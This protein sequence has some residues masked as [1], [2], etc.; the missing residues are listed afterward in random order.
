MKGFSLALTFLAAAVVSACTV[1]QTEAPPLTGPSELALSIS[2]SAS[3]DTLISGGLQQSSV[4]LQARDASGA[5]KANQSFLL[6]TTVDGVPTAYGTLTTDKITTGSDGRAT[7]IYTMPK[8]TP[9]DAGTPSRV[10]A[11]QAVS[12]GTDYSTA[13]Q[14]SVQLL[15][16]PPAVPAG[17]TGS[18]TASV[19]SSTTSAKVGQLVSFN[20]S[21]SLAAPG[22]SIVYYYWNFGDNLLNEEH[23]SDA[24]HA[25][26]SPGT[27][28]VIC[29]VQDEQGRTGSTF[30]TIVVTN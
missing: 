11:I 22:S 18:P 13:V 7:A 24:S 25:F 2:M 17:V 5:P 28:T 6:Y 19:T 10:V 20:A 30:K 21:G 16:V 12:T 8:F 3:P 26:A 1:H 27:F 4:S 15:V 23:G 29:G 9:Y 14:H